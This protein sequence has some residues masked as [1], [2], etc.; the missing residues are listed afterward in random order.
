MQNNQQRYGIISY[1][2]VNIGD[3][4]QSVASSRF[5]PKIDDHVYREQIA[6]FVS[7]SKKKVK[8]IMNGWWLWQPQNFPP[9]SFVNPLLISMHIQESI[10]NNFLTSKTKDFL[11]KFGPVGCRDLDTYNYLIENDIPAFTNIIR[12]L[13]TNVN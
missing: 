7:T 12:F 10:R 13:K 3:E 11:I 2:S 5:L 4:I 8:L 9:S 6:N 1:S